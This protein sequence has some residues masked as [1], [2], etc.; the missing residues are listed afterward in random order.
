MRA[1][2]R[3]SGGRVLIVDD[4]AALREL[5]TD[6]LSDTGVEIDAAASGQEALR[7]ALRRRPDL[8]VTDLRLGDCH[9][10]EVIDRLRSALGEVAAVVITGHGDVRVLTEA[11]RRRPVELM[12]KPLDVARLQQTVRRELSRQAQDRRARR[13]A[14]RLR[15]LARR[16]NLERKSVSRQLETT[17]A[18]L[19]EAYRSLS[20]RLSLQQMV[21][22]Y[23]QQLLSAGDDDSVFQALFRLFVRRSGPVFGVAM[24]CDDAAQ[25]QIVGRFGVPN[26]D[27]A[28]F[29]RAL[30]APLVDL[31]L[32]DPRPRTLDAGERSEQFA[33]N[34]R[35]YLVGLTLLTV[36][37]LPAAGEMIGLVVLYRKGEQPF[38]DDDVALAEMI[39]HPTAV[40]VRRNE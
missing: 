4:E 26:P 22:A 18:D 11:S 9:G 40:A 34:I 39:A 25:L 16:T 6:A 7:L 38:V 1:Q 20:G 27:A 5:L 17:C 3:S 37:L 10:L 30:T 35:E 13:R 8:V 28:G 2:Q 21:M 15:R 14:R 33:A 29:C 32:T 12:T 24:V 23:Q 36:P 31:V 19:T